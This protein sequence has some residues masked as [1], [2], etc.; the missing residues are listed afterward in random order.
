MTTAE[1]A[2]A[3]QA[4]T[5]LEI[6]IDRQYIPG[7]QRDDNELKERISKTSQRVEERLL[8]NKNTFF[9]KNAEEL[10]TSHADVPQIRVSAAA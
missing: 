6:E 8:N 4:Q 1:S 5:S 7:F 9:S 10:Q 2:D 3:D